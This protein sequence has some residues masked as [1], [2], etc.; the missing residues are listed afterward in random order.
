[1]IS[2]IPRVQIGETIRDIERMLLKKAKTFD[3]IDYVYVVD[4]NNVLRG[5][6]SIKEILGMPKK[7]VKIEEAMKK[8]LIVAYPLTL[9][10]RMVYLALS[11]NLKAIPVVDKRRR[12]LG[13]VPY[14]TILQIFNEEVRED[15]F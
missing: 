6:I 11:H 14:E 5:V 9:Q 1:M 8:D 7:D 13:I 4:E 15:V 10:E 2:T 12:L 3:T